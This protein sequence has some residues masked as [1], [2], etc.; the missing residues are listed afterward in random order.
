MV[1]KKGASREELKLILAVDRKVEN[2]LACA[3]TSN[4]YIFQVNT[5]IN[6]IT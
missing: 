2:D 4:L 1:N 3:Y 6:I 5:C